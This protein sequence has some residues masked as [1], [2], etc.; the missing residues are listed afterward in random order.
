M[1]RVAIQIQYAGFPASDQFDWSDELS[2]PFLCDKIVA[3]CVEMSRRSTIGVW[4]AESRTM[5]FFTTKTNYY[6]CPVDLVIW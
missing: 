1:A 4:Q 6:A 3:E 5:S 2:D